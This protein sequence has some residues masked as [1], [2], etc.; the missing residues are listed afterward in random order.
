MF[1][2]SRADA[3]AAHRQQM[4]TSITTPTILALLTFFLAMLAKSAALW[5]WRG[6]RAPSGS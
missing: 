2:P 1:Q 4:L 6:F 3:L 5:V